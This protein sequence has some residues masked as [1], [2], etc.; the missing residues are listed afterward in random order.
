MIQS[1]V[2]FF[3]GGGA[4]RTVLI[5]SGSRASSRFCG[6]CTSLTGRTGGGASSSGV[7]WRGMTRAREG[8]AS[9]MRGGEG[10]GE[11]EGEG[12][13]ARTGAPGTATCLAGSG[14]GGAACTSS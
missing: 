14:G 10:G 4:S 9:T 11:G 6:A 3:G 7:G 8:G 5:W 1:A 2:W 12:E 13:G